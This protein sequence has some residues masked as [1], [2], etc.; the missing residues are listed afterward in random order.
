[1]VSTYPALLFTAVLIGK[2]IVNRLKDSQ[3][4][5]AEAGGVAEELL[6]S[7]K[8]V[9]SFANF[10]YEKER[11]YNFIQVCYEKGLGSALRNGF[12]VGCLYLVL[13]G[14]YALAIW[15]GGTLLVSK[16][17]F[18]P[19]TNN[20]LGPGDIITVLMAT[21]IG[22]F[23]IG[24]A[25]P[26]Y[27]AISEACTTAYEFFKTYER[28]AQIDNS[29]ATLTPEKES[30]SGNIIFNGV[31][32]AYPSR[33]ADVIFNNIVLHIE[34]G[35]KTALVGESGTGK[36]TIIHLIERLYDFQ[37]GEIT[38]DGINIKHFDLHYL[39]SIIGYV[40]QEPVLFNTSI[41]ENILFGRENQF[42]DED[43]LRVN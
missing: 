1:M 10:K 13:F 9:V 15:Y 39:R 40:A 4:N 33:P 7:I 25:V 24:M 8:T 17:E 18:K 34:S 6:Y 19:G 30:I 22:A 16:S 26:N 3:K 2:A 42:N 12:G 31:T 5:F 32:F 11:F 36:T 38:L 27:R 41:R 28:I 43:I 14:S 23:T 21:V 29:M 37:D 20:P 35:K